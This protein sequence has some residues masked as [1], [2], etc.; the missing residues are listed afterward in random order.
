M[1]G[2]VRCTASKGV[3]CKLDKQ[4]LALCPTPLGVLLTVKASYDRDYQFHRSTRFYITLAKPREREHR[5]DRATI[6][7]GPVVRVPCLTGA[8]HQVPDSFRILVC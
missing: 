7:N 2:T 6:A 4:S 1:K 8:L 5:L 3:L